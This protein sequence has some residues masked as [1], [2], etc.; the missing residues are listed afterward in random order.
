MKA[1]FSMK[2]NGLIVSQILFTFANYLLWALILK[3]LGAVESVGNLAKEASKAGF[4][5]QGAT[6]EQGQMAASVV[7]G[8]YGIAKT[9]IYLGTTGL[10]IILLSKNGAYKTNTNGKMVLGLSCA[11][12][13]V[14][15]I[16]MTIMPSFPLYTLATIMLFMSKDIEEAQVFELNK[17]A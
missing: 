15:F 4:G 14:D 13:V 6:A 5:A 17:A 9:F 2:K 8:S 3:P 12:L 7:T 11:A 16:N 10:F 1:I